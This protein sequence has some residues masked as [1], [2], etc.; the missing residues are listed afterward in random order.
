MAQRPARGQSPRERDAALLVPLPPPNVAADATPPTDGSYA[1]SLSRWA[2]QRPHRVLAVW[3]VLAVAALVWLRAGPRVEGATAEL[4]PPEHRAPGDEVLLLLTP[5]PDRSPGEP[6]DVADALTVAAAAIAERM[7]DERVPLA[8]PVGEAAGWFDAHAMWLIGDDA[9][10]TIATRMSDAAMSDAIGELKARMSSPLFGV[11]SDEPRRDPLRL[12]G[13]L[14][15]EGS[16]YAAGSE[17]VG[18]PQQG[19]LPGG[20]RGPGR[21]RVTAAGDLIAEDGTAV[22]LLLRSERAPGVVLEQAQAL[23][24]EHGVQAE[25]VGAARTEQA[26][27]TLVRTRGLQL[28]ALALAGVTA[29]LA[30]VLRRVR[31]TLAIVGGLATVA[32]VTVALLPALDPWSV[33]I[34]VFLLGFCCEGALHL[35]RISARG[36]P[37]AAVLA[38][39]LLPLLLSPYPVWQT[40]AWRWPLAVAAGMVVLRVVLPA[41]HAV[42]GGAVSWEGRGFAWRAMPGLALGAGLVV[43]AAGAWSVSSLR[44]RGGDRVGVAAV[45]ASQQRLVDEFF[46]P[47]ALARAESRGADAAAALDRAAVEGRALAALVPG[48]ATRVDGPGPW[49]ARREDLDRRRAALAELK[50]PARLESLRAILEARGFR[51]DA[52]GE[53]LRGAAGDGGLPTAGAMLQGPLGG[54]L[55]RYLVNDGD[56]RVRTFVQLGAD[57]DAGVPRVRAPDGSAVTLVGPPV[58]ARIDRERFADWLGIWALC[59]LW[60]GA[61]VVWLGTRSL[62]VALASAF[63]TL[64]TQCAVLWLLTLLRVPV[65]PSMVPALL[66]VGASATVS[67]GRACRAVDLQRPLFA[68]GIVVTSLCQLA[69]GAALAASG[70]PLW[71]PLGLVVVVGAAIASGAGLFV[72][73]G[74]CA[75]L[76]R[77]FGRDRAAPPSQEVP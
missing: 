72:A 17:G 74:V 9:L 52:F 57:A 48:E 28:I 33:A 29:V 75:M 58:A 45:A 56:V 77:A 37:A 21:S 43:L 18:G 13:L 60:L 67:A 38:S 59:Q 66:L 5:A 47:A 42:V 73:P 71:R 26:A 34:I 61:F 3:L 40:W 49:I 41:M 62:G 14:G 55:R 44:Y 15:A 4:L 10:A 19:A 65:G 7:A 31:A 68:T 1:I 63:A 8:P 24:A 6:G 20:D 69:A 16:R 30:G 76:R 23:I 22:L 2:R 32:L 70:E 36:W 50:L 64:V 51:A 46:D 53:F 11:A 25:L 39:A 27:A 12:Y 54:W 35:Q